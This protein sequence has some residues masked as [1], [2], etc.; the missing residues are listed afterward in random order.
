MN[1]TLRFSI[2]LVLAAVIG[3][4]QSGSA[5]SSNG[6]VLAAGGY[7]VP[8][9]S[10]AVA[11]GQITVLHVHGIT[12][13]FP[14]S[15]ITGVPTPSGLPH[16]L[17]GITVDLIQGKDGSTISLELRAAYQ[18]NCLQPCS[19]ITGITLQIPFELETDY[20]ARNDPPPTLRI[21][22]NGKVTG[23]VLLKPVTDNVHVINTCDDSQIFISAAYSVPQSICASDVM[24]AGTLNSLYN[25]AHGG[26]ELAMWLYGMGAVTPQG[27]NCCNSPDQLSQPVQTFQLNFDYRPNAPASPAVA[28]FGITSAP[29]FAT[30]GTGGLYQV[31]F[32]VP[33]VPTGLPACD[34]MR[35]KSNLTVTVTGPN[36]YDAAQICVAVQ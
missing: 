6:I 15:N 7:Q 23:A 19:Q 2:V 17:N 1:S 21:S 36:S 8:G 28:G 13:Q 16:V 24:G 11:P 12:T 32:G 4:A 14:T 29:L 27:P 31:N 20:L 34:G 26:D 33:P 25:L 18:V 9:L 3:A 5:D 30:G 35:I 22:E 10:L